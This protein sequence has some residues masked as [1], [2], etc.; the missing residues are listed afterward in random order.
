MNIHPMSRALEIMLFFCLL[1]APAMALQM[2]AQPG[3]LVITSTPPGARII[4]N[5]ELRTDVTDVTLVV[6]PGVYKVVVG[7]CSEQTVQISSGETKQ[8]HCP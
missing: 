6:S 4:I 1:L 2:P 7:S 3:K 5:G 8:V